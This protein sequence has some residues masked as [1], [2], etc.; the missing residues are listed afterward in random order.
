MTQTQLDRLV[1]RATGEDIRSI[2]RR[3]FSLANLVEVNFDPEPDQRP[4]QL[5]DWDE[6]DKE[7]GELLN[8]R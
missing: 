6:L 1:A 8:A 2:R 4:P 5:V 3:G 7:R